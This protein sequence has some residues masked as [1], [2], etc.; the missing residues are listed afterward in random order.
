MKA[1][2]ISQPY[3]DLIANLEKWVEN[4][5]WETALRGWIAI[6][7]G[8]GTQYLGR[9]ELKD[10]PTGAIVA[11]SKLTPAGHRQESLIAIPGTNKS[12]KQF[13][14]HEH[15]E[16]PQCFILEHTV[17][18]IT[19]IPCPGARM[20]WNV[21]DVLMPKLRDQIRT[22][23]QRPFNAHRFENNGS[24][25]QHQVQS[26]E[27]MRDLWDECFAKAK[28]GKTLEPQIAQMNADRDA[29]GFLPRKVGN[30]R[31]QAQWRSQ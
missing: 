17:K 1:L 3:A 7:A 27:A 26:I 9:A 2:T 12:W 31:L 20:F 11:L 18:L 14:N 30:A 29:S 5:L 8:K 28:R 10:Y 19:P 25:E 15:T 4:R 16:G 6:H 23:R 21:P 22:L 24:S 13:Y